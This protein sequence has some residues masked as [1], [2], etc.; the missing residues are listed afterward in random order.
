MYLSFVCGTF[1]AFRVKN[2]GSKQAEG[3]SYDLSRCVKCLKNWETALLGFHA[4][5]GCDS[6]SS[7]A[8]IGKKTGWDVLKRSAAHQ[9]AL[10]LVGQREQLNERTAAKVEAYVCDLCP[11]SKITEATAESK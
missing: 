11:T 1:A 2:Y 3:T 10:R 4:L 8:G 5:T 7:L 6:T 9:N